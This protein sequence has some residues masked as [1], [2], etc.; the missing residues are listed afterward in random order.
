MNCKVFYKKLLEISNQRMLYFVVKLN[1]SL[2]KNRA[3][4][5]GLSDDLTNDANLEFPNAYNRFRKIVFD[6]DERI[7]NILRCY[8]QPCQSDIKTTNIDT[9]YRVY[10]K[11]PPIHSNI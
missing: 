11:L 7:A 9:I 3:S 4:F 8:L 10:E 5:L 2:L 6:G 1:K